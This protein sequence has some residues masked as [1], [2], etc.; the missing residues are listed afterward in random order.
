MCHSMLEGE[1]ERCKAHIMRAMRD[2]QPGL[3]AK[4]I[5]RV[6]S[7][8]YGLTKR[9][10]K[11]TGP[12]KKHVL[13]EATKAYLTDVYDDSDEITLAINL[14]D[15]GIETTVLVSKHTG[16]CGLWK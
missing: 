15:M 14:I 13:L 4:D 1:I 8:G 3:Q 11:L 12:Q 2:D 10:R 6:V 9:L 5:A 7:A 16:C